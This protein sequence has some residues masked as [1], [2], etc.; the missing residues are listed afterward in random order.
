MVNTV[1]QSGEHLTGWIILNP[2]QQ[3]VTQT[4]PIYFFSKPMCFFEIFEFKQQIKQQHISVFFWNITTW[5]I[6]LLLQNQN[7]FSAVSEPP[8]NS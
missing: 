8:M 7:I 2:D 5:S 4:Q 6:L 3:K 1:P